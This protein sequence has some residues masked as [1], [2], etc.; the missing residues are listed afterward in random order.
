[1][2][3]IVI[4]YLSTTPLIR[5]IFA[6]LIESS[7]LQENQLKARDDIILNFDPKIIETLDQLHKENIGLEFKACLS[8]TEENK[9]YNI[10]SIYEPVTFLKEYDQVISE[11]CKENTLISLHS[12]PLKHCLPSAQDIKTFNKFKEKNSKALMVIMCE[13]E[14]FNVY[15]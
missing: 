14:R 7:K 6:G 4:F 2:E 12:H 8:G 13:K 11:P 3:E 1:M 9:I 10:T 15:S 5:S